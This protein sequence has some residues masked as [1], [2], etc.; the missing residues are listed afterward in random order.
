MTTY[1]DKQ[2]NKRQTNVEKLVGKNDNNLTRKMT[3][4]LQHKSC[5]DY[6]D[7]AIMS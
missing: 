4:K 2:T 6:V 1:D 3:S 7:F 5:M